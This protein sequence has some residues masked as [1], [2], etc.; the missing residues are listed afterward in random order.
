MTVGQPILQKR[1]RA[2]L[3]RG[4]KQIADD[5]AQSQGKS[6]KLAKSDVPNLWERLKAH[7]AAVLLFAKD[8]PTAF[9]NNRAEQDLR[10]AKV[11]QMVSGCFRAEDYVHAYY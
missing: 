4:E 6:G 2:I 3:T 5:S 9:T 1:Y 7:E 11:M 8:P 10:M